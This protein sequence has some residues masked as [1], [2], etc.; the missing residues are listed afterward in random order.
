MKKIVSSILLL[1]VLFSIGLT[2]NPLKVNAEPLITKGG[3]DYLLNSA[4][5]GIE[6]KI[7]TLRARIERLQTQINNIRSKYFYTLHLVI[8]SSKATITSPGGSIENYTLDSN[9]QIKNSRT[10]VPLRFIGEALGAKIDWDNKTR[11]V[12]YTTSD[13]VVIL[14]VGK[15]SATIN[16]KNY[17]LDC[18]PVIVND[19]T[20]VPVRFISE[21]LGASVLWDNATRSIDITYI[22]GK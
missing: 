6:C 19:R 12:S 1:C 20:L 8:D 7:T 18:A 4:T 22:K 15:T 17:T 5:N 13:K 21:A 10:L 16:G 11:S 14:T 2:I 9:P 3:V